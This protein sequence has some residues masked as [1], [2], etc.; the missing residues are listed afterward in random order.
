M[1][2]ITVTI[3]PSINKY[4]GVTGNGQAF[5]RH[6]RLDQI[7]AVDRLAEGCSL[8]LIGGKRISLKGESADDFLAK[9]DE[10]FD[11]ETG[12]AFQPA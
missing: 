1:R 11:A 12:R 3:D 4:E 5:T 9:F 7:L 2:W 8:A 10:L 6:L